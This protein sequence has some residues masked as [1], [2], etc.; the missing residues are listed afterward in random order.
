MLFTILFILNQGLCRLPNLQKLAALNK[1]NKTMTLLV[2]PHFNAELVEEK[3]IPKIVFAHTTTTTRPTTTKAT[4][5]RDDT[6]ETIPIL[7]VEPTVPPFPTFAPDV[8]AADVKVSELEQ[9]RLRLLCK[10]FKPGYCK[11]LLM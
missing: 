4:T 3:P 2:R 8:E 5:T 1:M 11:L 9:L 7:P 6:I 10:T